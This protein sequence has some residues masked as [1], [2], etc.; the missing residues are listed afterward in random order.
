MIRKEAV[1][2]LASGGLD[3]AILISE[4]TKEYTEIYP[5]YIRNGLRWEEIELKYLEQFLKKF[6]HPA[7]QPL[8][9]LDLPIQDLQKAH[10]S[11]TGK[12]VPDADAEDV[13]VYIPGR[14]IFLLAKAGVWCNLKDIPTLAIGILR[15]NPFPDATPS[16]FGTLEASFSEGLRF[17]LSIITPL[18]N[19]TKKEAILKGKEL[20]L[21][22]T[23]SCFSPRVNKHCGKCN[24]CDERKRAFQKAGIPDPTPYA[25]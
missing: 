2:V 7:L 14:N 22:L 20:P 24:K 21:G 18:S 4:M 9:I 10:W 17:A 12:D 8:T 5:L 19:L 3:S 23:F 6:S 11:V 16:F 1:A 15:G 25:G 13:A